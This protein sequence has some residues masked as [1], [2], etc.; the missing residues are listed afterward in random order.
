MK[1]ILQR[2]KCR[3]LRLGTAGVGPSALRPGSGLHLIMVL[4]SLLPG[5][6][7]AAGVGTTA[8]QFLKIGVG[9]RDLA[10]G[11]ATVAVADNAHTLYWNPAGATQI[12]SPELGASYNSLYQDTSQGYIGYVHP[13]GR[14]A[15]GGA[16][17]YLQVAKI[18]ARQGDTASPDYTF[19]SRDTALMGSY[20]YADVL[21]GLSLGLNAKYLQLHLDSKHARAFAVDLGSLYKVRGAPL[22][23]GL[24]VLNVGSNV[25]FDSV[26]DPLPLGIKAGVAYRLWGEKL[27]IA[28]GVDAWL[29][30]KRTYGELGMEWK[31]LSLLAIRAGYQLGRAQDQ[32]GGKKIGLGAGAGFHLKMVTVDYAFVPFG[33]LGDTHRFSLGLKF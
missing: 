27:L 11:G 29:R 33:D 26:S 6:V 2:P 32:L 30:D 7:W 22:T 8:A 21:P 1:Q 9:A 15:W 25:K 4:V 12:K 24:T 19:A 5:A 14:S 31:P 18:E 13:A 3:R 23:L 28:T 17:D 20:A 10:M 16:V